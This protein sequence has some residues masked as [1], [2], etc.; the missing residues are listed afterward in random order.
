MSL[1]LLAQAT[2]S[3]KYWWYA[4]LTATYIINKIPYLVLNHRSLFHKLH[5]KAFLIISIPHTP[6]PSHTTPT[7]ISPSLLNNY[8]HL[9]TTSSF[10]SL[11]STPTPPSQIPSP[12]LKALITVAVYYIE[13]LLKKDNN[14]S[15]MSNMLE[16]SFEVALAAYVEDKYDSWGVFLQLGAVAFEATRLSGY[17]RGLGHVLDY[18]H[19]QSIV[20]KMIQQRKYE[21]RAQDKLNVPKTKKTFWLEDVIEG[22]SRVL[23][24]VESPPVPQQRARNKRDALPFGPNDRNA[25]LSAFCPNFS[26][27][28]DGLSGKCRRLSH[29]PM[30]AAR[31]D[32]GERIYNGRGSFRHS[33][34]SSELLGFRVLFQISQGFCVSKPNKKLNP[35][36]KNIDNKS[37]RFRGKIAPSSPFAP[38][39]HHT[40]GGVYDSELSAQEFVFGDDVQNDL[41]EAIICRGL[42]F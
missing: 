28:N 23:V 11:L 12:M 9:S 16:I 26:L 1:T 40:Y 4:F 15:T 18:H 27:L 6:P 7:P 36:A 2:L 29:V 25:A 20:R 37:C 35:K 34:I 24:L 17:M 22:G 8:P 30:H 19:W 32:E 42:K 5:H 33:L 38:I 14:S 41:N 39:V 10:T 3:S 13:I 21:D 31:F